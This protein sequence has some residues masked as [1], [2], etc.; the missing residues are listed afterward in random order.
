MSECEAVLAKRL[1]MVQIIADDLIEYAVLSD[2]FIE[3]V[4][5]SAF[6]SNP[7]AERE[8]LI[9][10]RA[11]LALEIENL[12]KSIALGG[13]IPALAKALGDRDK[14]LKANSN[15]LLGRITLKSEGISW[16]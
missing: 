8:L 14:S 16:S 10:E 11:R 3:R 2:A 9:T 12:T 7:D 4:L 1:G 5:E 15:A 13:D 6:T